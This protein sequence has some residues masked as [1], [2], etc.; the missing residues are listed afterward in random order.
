MK[1]SIWVL[2]LAALTGSLSN[3]CGGESQ[4]AELEAEVSQLSE[5]LDA[6]LTTSVPGST[7]SAS[8]AT[9]TATFS[10]SS[11]STSS[12]TSSTTTSVVPVASQPAP[13][14]QANAADNTTATT[15]EPTTTVT[16]APPPTTE[17]PPSTER[18]PTTT[19]LPTVT[20]PT[21]TAPAPPT[22]TA[23][24]YVPTCYIEDE[25]YFV[26]SAMGIVVVTIGLSPDVAG[27]PPPPGTSL[28]YRTGVSSDPDGLALDYLVWGSLRD[29]STVE[30]QF[31][32]DAEVAAGLVFS[33]TFSL[34]LT[35]STDVDGARWTC[36]REFIITA[37]AD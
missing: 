9:S 10:S 1:V 4:L 26:D 30:V 32:Y 15:V 29:S 7:E 20:V 21:T 22:T 8:V 33:V 6:A 31:N 2:A 35:N 28:V 34:T 25:P 24:A 3:A 11:G 5:A 19:S 37:P 18:P 23:P 14:P 13:S 27:T 17:P 36:S 16:M 12:S